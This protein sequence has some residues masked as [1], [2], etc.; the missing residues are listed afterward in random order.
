MVKRSLQSSAAGIQQSKRAF[1]L[2]G[3]TQENLAGEVN[4]K[5]RQPIWRFFTGQPVD[6]QVF[7]EICSVLD[8]NWREI[9]VDIPAEFPEPSGSVRFPRPDIDSLVQQVRSQRYDRIQDQCGILQLL[10]ISHPVSLDDIYVDVNILEAI[11]KHQ[12]LEIANLQHLEPEAFDR[13]GLGEVDQKQ[14]S[15][16]RAVE[17]YPKLRVLCKP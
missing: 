10:D 3:W 4:L 11:A 1:A 17:T 2:K 6:R 16:M 9:A 14:I 13:V 7:L 5:T 15:G 8:L 12:Q